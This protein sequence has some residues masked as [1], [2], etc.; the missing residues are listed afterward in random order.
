M[1]LIPTLGQIWEWSLTQ[2]IWIIVRIKDSFVEMMLL[3]DPLC[4][5][6]A[7]KLCEFSFLHVDH[8]NH[9]PWRLFEQQS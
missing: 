8:R 2:E 6:L 1:R 7:G 3:D 9:G 4:E 5:S